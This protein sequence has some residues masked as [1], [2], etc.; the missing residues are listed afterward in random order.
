M[1]P[2]HREE[3]VPP[4]KYSPASFGEVEELPTFQLTRVAVAVDWISTQELFVGPAEPVVLGLSEPGAAVVVE[5]ASDRLQMADHASA[6]IVPLGVLV[7]TIERGPL[8]YT[9]VDV[10]RK[11]RARAISYG[12][13]IESADGGDLPP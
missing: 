11:G 5:L 2:E 13:W 10:G 4:I 3:K 12:L 7:S 9:V 8:C 6:C 1:K